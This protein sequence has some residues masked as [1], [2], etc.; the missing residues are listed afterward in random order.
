MQ[1]LPP[2]DSLS[3]GT[4]GEWIGLH[5]K[6]SN[7]LF[8]APQQA[9]LCACS[10]SQITASRLRRS[11][12][13]R[14]QVQFTFCTADF[15]LKT[16]RHIGSHRNVEKKPRVAVTEWFIPPVFRRM[17]LIVCRTFASAVRRSR[18]ESVLSLWSASEPTQ[19]QPLGWGPHPQ[20]RGFPAIF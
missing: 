16:P 2:A 3:S 10:C 15:M 6:S 20:E 18:C 5:L 8:N 19:N 4:S 14:V 12:P 17:F 1:G 13:E 11:T 7:V 9:H